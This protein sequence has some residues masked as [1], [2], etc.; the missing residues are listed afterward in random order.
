MPE[1]FRHFVKSLI[2]Q[3]A[4]N[5]YIAKLNNKT[6]TKFVCILKEMYHF[7]VV[8]CVATL[9]FIASSFSNLISIYSCFL[10]SVTHG[11]CFAAEF[12]LLLTVRR[13]ILQSCGADSPGDITHLWRKVVIIVCNRYSLWLV[14]RIITLISNTILLPDSKWAPRLKVGTFYYGCFKKI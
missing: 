2:T 10:I 11:C 14:G 13:F 12:N 4:C 8:D 5:I 1:H 6:K 3:F 7:Y 9:Q